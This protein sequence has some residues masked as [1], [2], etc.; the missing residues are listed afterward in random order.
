MDSKPSFMDSDDSANRILRTLHGLAVPTTTLQRRGTMLKTTVQNARVAAVIERSDEDDGVAFA[1]DLLLDD[2]AVVEVVHPRF[3][4]SPSGAQ[5]FADLVFDPLTSKNSGDGTLDDQYVNFTEQH[6]ALI[7][8][9]AD[10]DDAMCGTD[11]EGPCRRAFVAIGHITAAD[12]VPLPSPTVVASEHGADAAVAVPAQQWFE[13]T[14]WLSG[15]FCMDVLTTATYE[16]FCAELFSPE[17]LHSEH[18][19]APWGERRPEEPTYD[20][21]YCVAPP[22]KEQHHA[23]EPNAPESTADE[24]RGFEVLESGE[25][26]PSSLC[27]VQQQRPVSRSLA[28]N[29]SFHES[30][31]RTVAREMAQTLVR[32]ALEASVREPPLMI[33]DGPPRSEDDGQL[34][35]H[36]VLDSAES[37]SNGTCS[38]Q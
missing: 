37:G 28:S 38:I 6:C 8:R 34:G 31:E 10:P 27:V 12:E 33:A 1:Y 21:V 5:D 9:A 17:G 20:C 3:G 36:D 14:L 30:F 19:V 32:E 25:A 15:G 22:G 13:H 29:L 35:D 2:G 26:N 7:T 18:A 11:G 4:G 16:A 23:L 24:F